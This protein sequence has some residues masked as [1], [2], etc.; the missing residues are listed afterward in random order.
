MGEYQGRI[1]ETSRAL[2]L[3]LTGMAVREE[4]VGCLYILG[5]G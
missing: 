5:A 4:S 1:N 2:V 3:L